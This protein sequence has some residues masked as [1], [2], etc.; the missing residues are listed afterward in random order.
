MAE[1]RL[2]HRENGLTVAI[3]TM[4]SWRGFLRGQLPVYLDHPAISYV[5]ICD[6]TGNDIIDMYEERIIDHPKLRVYQNDIILGAYENKRQCMLKAPT[7][8]VAVLDS[9]N[10]FD[11]EFFN[12]FINCI[13]RKGEPKKT[14]YCAGLAE[15]F[16]PLTASTE[17]RTEHFNGMKV[18]Y[19]NWNTILEIREWDIL[20]NS[21]N[22]IWPTKVVRHFPEI[23]KEISD[24][25]DNILF[26]QAAIRAGYTMS[27]EPTM[28]YVHTVLDD[29]YTSDLDVKDWII[30]Y[31][32]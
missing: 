14:I 22:I 28:H 4:N 25:I 1:E 16:L 32:C 27:I 18:S 31:G 23:S 15:R 3:P 5:I 12:A 30:R 17:V 21:G 19:D 7:K 9:S 2:K 10:L 20:L 26:I 8:W 6:E 24:G 13:M 29:T 11:P